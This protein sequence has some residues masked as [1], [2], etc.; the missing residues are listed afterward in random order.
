[1]ATTSNDLINLYERAR[2]TLQNYHALRPDY[3]LTVSLELEE[4]D[5]GEC[6]PDFII[7]YKEQTGHRSSPSIYAS[8]GTP[9][10]A[11]DDLAVKRA[12]KARMGR[13]Q[14]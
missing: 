7:W 11:L 10:L 6:N 2:T 4:D 9:A 12:Q 1:M 8:G 3:R 14:Y 5:A 13:Y